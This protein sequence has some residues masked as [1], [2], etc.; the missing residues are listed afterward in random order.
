M[1]EG[2]AAVQYIATLCAR[3]HLWQQAGESHHP[4]IK[5]GERRPNIVDP[6][7]HQHCRG[8]PEDRV[9]HFAVRQQLI[10][11]FGDIRE[12]HRAVIIHC[13]RQRRLQHIT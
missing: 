2:L 1:I 11:R 7:I 12:R 5:V 6:Q 9:I 13:V 10:D 3:V 8:Q 4:Q